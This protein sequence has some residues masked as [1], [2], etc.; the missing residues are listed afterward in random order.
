MNT[1]ITPEEI[2]KKLRR[3]RKQNGFYQDEIGR[4]L[5]IFSRPNGKREPEYLPD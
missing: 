4:I 3:I 1:A 2:G 5:K